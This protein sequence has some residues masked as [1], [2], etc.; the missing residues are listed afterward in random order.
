MNFLQFA[1]WGAYL[2]CMGTYLHG[3]LDKIMHR[4]IRPILA[5]P[6]RYVYMDKAEY[7][8]LKEMGIK[9]QINI[10]SLVGAYGKEAKEK[11]E[12]MLKE[13]W[14]ELTGTD[15]HKLH[16]IQFAAKQKILKKTTVKQLREIHSQKPF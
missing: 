15:V 9:F 10:T 13:K 1:V 8:T 14:V 7:R 11:A 4:G 3:I 16:A 2:T 6:E 12:M 5:H